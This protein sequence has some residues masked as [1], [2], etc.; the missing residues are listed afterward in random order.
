[1]N[2]I[3][4]PNLQA[5]HTSS[6][7]PP[8]FC[9]RGGFPLAAPCP[10]TRHSYSGGREETSPILEASFGKE[11][12]RGSVLFILEGLFLNLSNSSTLHENMNKKC[13]QRTTLE[14]RCDAMAKSSIASSIFY[15]LKL[16][17]AREIIPTSL[18]SAFLLRKNGVKKEE[19][20]RYLDGNISL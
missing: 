6:T 8:S 17:P 7:T 13:F 1:M 15:V 2:G 18:T 11:K 16:S 20:K 5:P 3:V 4:N 12:F 19:G 9:E 14:M 10:P